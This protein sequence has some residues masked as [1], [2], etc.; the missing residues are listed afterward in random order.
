M[1]FSRLWTKTLD[2]YIPGKFCGESLPSSVLI[3]SNSVRLNFVS[4][5]TDHAAGFNLT[6]KALKPNYLPGKTICLYH[7]QPRP[8]R[9][10]EA[11]QGWS[12]G[13]GAPPQGLFGSITEGATRQVRGH[14]GAPSPV[15]LTRAD[16][17]PKW[18]ERVER[19]LEN[20]CTDV[21]LLISSAWGVSWWAICGRQV[22]AHRGLI[23]LGLSDAIVRTFSLV[24]QIQVAVPLLSFLKKASYR[25]FTILNTIATWPT[26]TGFFKPPNTT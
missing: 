25:V 26:V 21:F 22:E 17:V 24:F 7:V 6:Y 11:P 15:L 5:A 12:E 14:E 3:G 23:P 10:V 1:L 4:D 8:F 16:H 19:V 18:A 13:Q 2:S 20:Q 9:E